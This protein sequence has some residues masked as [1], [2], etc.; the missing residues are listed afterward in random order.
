MS[1]KK[2]SRTTGADFAN[3]TFEDDEFKDN[4]ALN[5]PSRANRPVRRAS[6]ANAH[7]H[8]QYASHHLG[9]AS[10]KIQNPPL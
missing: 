4:K 5:A 8:L 9:K 10:L 1:G 2:Q 3:V 7:L 6:A